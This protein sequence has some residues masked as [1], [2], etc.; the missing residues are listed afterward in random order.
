MHCDHDHDPDK[1]HGHEHHHTGEP[2]GPLHRAVF[3]VTLFFGRGGMA[4]TVADLAGVSAGDVVVDVGCGAGAAV[5]RARRTG[6]ARAVGIDP[7]P[8]MLAFARRFTSLRRLDGVEFVEGSA[9]S[10]PLDSGSATVVWAVQSVHHWVDRARALTEVRR[11]LAPRGRLLLM[12][13]AV[14][15]GARGLASHGLTE[16]RA[17]ELAGLIERTGFAGTARQKVPVGRR[18]FVVVTASAPPTPSS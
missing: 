8:E 7:S 13:R 3:T 5:R 9:E 18:H 10:L 11:V 2:R 16:Q 15:P 6:A 4:R 12:E 14:V 1:D 17:E